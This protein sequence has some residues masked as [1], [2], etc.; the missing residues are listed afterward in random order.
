MTDQDA[1]GALR[2]IAADM[3]VRR[4]YPQS[5]AACERGAAA[6]EAQARIAPWLPLVCEALED[7]CLCELEGECRYCRARAAL[8][9]ERKGDNRG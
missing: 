8:S 4:Y 9:G 5:S 1:I 2:E 6:I 7:A 3:D